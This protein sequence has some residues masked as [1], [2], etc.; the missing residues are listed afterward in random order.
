MTFL[1]SYRHTVF[2]EL[3][4]FLKYLQYFFNQIGNY[5]KQNIL[6]KLQ[7]TVKLIKSRSFQNT[8]VFFI[9]SDWKFSEFSQE[10]IIMS[11]FFPA[12]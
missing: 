2:Q 11:K 8:I 1:D 7:R 3:E 5:G 6:G 12:N 10:K 9:S 4:N